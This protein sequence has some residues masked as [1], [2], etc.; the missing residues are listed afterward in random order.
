MNDETG[1]DVPWDKI[2]KA[3]EYKSGNYVVLS[4]EELEKANVE[5]TH[6][7]DIEQ[8]VDLDDIDPLYFDKPYYLVPDKG[9][10]KG[11]VLLREAIESARKAGIVRV[12]LRTRQYLAAVVARNGA[13]MLDLLR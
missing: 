2:A 3:Y 13:L 7:I 1:E 11:Y 9:G 6:T 5:M 12:V 10:E 8:F 4:E